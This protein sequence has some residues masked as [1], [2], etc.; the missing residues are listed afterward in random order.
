MLTS[1]A[2]TVKCPRCNGT[3]HLPRYC[4]DG[5]VCFLCDGTGVVEVEHLLEWQEES[6]GKVTN[7]EYLKFHK[8]DGISEETLQIIRLWFGKTRQYEDLI[9]DDNSKEALRKLW[10][11]C[12][13]PKVSKIM[14]HQEKDSGGW[15]ILLLSERRWN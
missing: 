2:H 11:D 7:I 5:G 4:H 13:L 10:K 14:L 8:Y 3:G 6:K 9:I 12:K 1:T 15:E